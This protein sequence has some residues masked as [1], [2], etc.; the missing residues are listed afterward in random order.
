MLNSSCSPTI[1]ASVAPLIFPAHSPYLAVAISLSSNVLHQL[2][3]DLV[4]NSE[5]GGSRIN[6]RL[7]ALAAPA[8]AL[9]TNGEAE[10]RE[11]KCLVKLLAAAGE[12]QG[13]SV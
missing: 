5:E 6:D 8:T 9:P 4:G 1:D 10:G 11:N 7:A 12:T 2:T 3:E 13:H